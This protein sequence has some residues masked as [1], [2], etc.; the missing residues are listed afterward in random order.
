MEIRITALATLLA[1]L[2]LPLAS[3]AGPVPNLVDACLASPLATCADSLS[4]R[5]KASRLLPSVMVPEE[6]AAPDASQTAPP[7]PPEGA[8]TPGTP[9]SAAVPSETAAG[10]G[11]RSPERFLLQAVVVL[12]A[13][14]LIL[15][16]LVLDAK[17]RKR[18]RQ[19]TY[20]DVER[21]RRMQADI[22]DAW[23]SAR[24]AKP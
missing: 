10:P 12:A 11:G 9:A 5:V 13:L 24:A 18:A 16:V 1:T 6:P 14:A 20:G 8:D 2:G 21:A 4:P 3:A 23:R 7:A 15:V 19:T 22:D 17:E